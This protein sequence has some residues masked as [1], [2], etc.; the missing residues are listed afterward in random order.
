MAQ[1]GEGGAL[2]AT[3]AELPVSGA[4][5]PGG[6][7]QGHSSP[8]RPRRPRVMQEG[9]EGVAAPVTVVEDKYRRESSAEGS[10]LSLQFSTSVAGPTGTIRWPT[11]AFELPGDPEDHFSHHLDAA[12]LLMT[13]QTA[14]EA[15][16]SPLTRGGAG[17]QHSADK[18]ELASGEVALDGLW[19]AQRQAQRQAQRRAQQRGRTVADTWEGATAGAQSSLRGAASPGLP[20]SLA[21]AL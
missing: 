19:R 3:W 16:G 14:T 4:E 7:A 8:G 10:F 2:S 20:I 18:A 12:E 17:R 11:G 1:Q 13:P 5:G 9:T 15:R 21:G 6:A